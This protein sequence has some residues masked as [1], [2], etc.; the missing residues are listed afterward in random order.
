MALLRI[1]SP[2]EDPARHAKS[3][4][5]HRAIADAIARREPEK[6]REAMQVVIGEG[7]AGAAGKGR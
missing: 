6:A 4:A 2:I 3:V 7:I 5:A 1:S